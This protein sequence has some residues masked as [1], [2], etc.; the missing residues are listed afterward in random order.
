MHEHQNGLNDVA[1]LHR[2]M[3]E[4]DSMERENRGPKKTSLESLSISSAD[5]AS[6]KQADS[7]AKKVAGGGKV[8]GESL[9]STSATVNAS[10]EE[11]AMEIPSGFSGKL[12]AASGGGSP[13]DDNTRG[14]M[15]SGLGT[16]LSDV[17]VHTGSAADDLSQSINAKAF[18]HGKDIYF[19]EGQYNPST[20]QGKELLAHELVH[21]RQGGN[22]IQR[23]SDELH[24][25][26]FYASQKISKSMEAIFHN[27]DKALENFYETM[28]AD[29]PEKMSPLDI[30]L[31]VFKALFSP[32]VGGI[33]ERVLESF[34]NLGATAIDDIMQ[35]VTTI[36][37]TV[38]TITEKTGEGKEI[39]EKRYDKSKKGALLSFYTKMNSFFGDAESTVRNEEDWTAEAMQKKY[40]EL[41][42]SN[43][44]EA[45]VMLT[46]LEDL[47]Q[48][49]HDEFKKFFT[50]DNL[51]NRLSLQWLK[52]G[53]RENKKHN[54]A[55]LGST[56]VHIKIDSNWEIE[57][58]VVHGQF[59]EKI[60]EM[61]TENYEGEEINPWNLA[62]DL[63]RSEDDL[64]DLSLPIKVTY[65]APD[66]TTNPPEPRWAEVWEGVSR[67]RPVQGSDDEMI[68]ALTKNLPS[69][70][71][72]RVKKLE[73]KG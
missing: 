35:R 21:T 31:V 5:D 12:S 11:G 3:E 28:T 56:Y 15:E 71:K 2:K 36:S 68:K 52:R 6:E 73:G 19:K 53:V 33:L 24:G 60:A 7:L 61:M 20:S 37:E 62:G 16:D 41:E 13:L 17:R 47:A 25:P 69:L 8:S 4:D 59:G 43:P 22:K 39:L 9:N 57:E 45:K 26:V 63:Q 50:I 30:V 1:D 66:M 27:Q 38:T 40:N 48:K 46:G 67:A 10:G 55:R 72:K 58:A 18:A 54:R 32:F 29:T 49:L 51:E 34:T 14:Q 64:A 70:R 44:G 42:K 23:L 65:S